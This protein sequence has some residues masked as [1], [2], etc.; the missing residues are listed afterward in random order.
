VDLFNKQVAQLADQFRS[1]SAAGRMTAGLLLLV[2]VVGAAYLFNHPLSATEGYL[3]GGEA[4]SSSQLPAIEAAFGKKNLSD[5]QVQANRICVP[6]GKQSVY[7]AALADA[8]ALPH[9]F[10]DSMKTSLDSGGPFVD[11]KKREELVKVALQE[12]LSKIIGQMNGIER[13][14]VLYNVEAPQGFNAKK[15]ITAS[16]TV[17]PVGEKTLGSE[18][19]QMIRQAVGP[20]IG[21]APESVAIVDIN[22]RAYP[23]GETE[24]TADINQ[25][26][27]LRAK[28]QYE[29]EYADSIHQALDS[30]VKGAVV[31]VNIELHPEFVDIQTAVQNNA[32]QVATDASE[33]SKSLLA[34]TLLPSGIQNATAGAPNSPLT[35]SESSNTLRNPTETT[36]QTDRNAASPPSRLVR[37]TPLTPKRVSVSVGVPSSYY[38]Q[39]WGQRNQSAASAWSAKPSP[40]AIAQLESETNANIKKIVMG[41]VPL[42]DASAGDS[43][44]VASF[45]AVSL[46]PIEKPAATDLA[47][48]WAIDHASALG[49]ALLAIVCLLIVRSMARAGATSG[50][51]QRYD[52]T[53]SRTAA[54]EEMIDIQPAQPSPVR[55]R[56]RPLAGGSPRDELV[57]IVRD[58]PDAAAE[59]LRNWIGAAN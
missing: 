32:P 55:P 31:A 44:T 10:L 41:I 35:V 25:S 54:T 38:E 51:D 50:Y 43:V 18:Q 14:T 30:F 6:Q 37:S 39:V 24:S 22:G 33:P 52:T 21:A 1:M 2:V 11:R 40:A 5:Y 53:T 27:Y 19:V 17:K 28:H 47:L 42:T 20:A 13:A 26:R 58:D 15:Q 48:G 8:G 29:K 23:G 59:V 46:A 12:E 49:I 57:E 7:M 56:R 45:A 9:N 34:K 36:A 3:F 16:V 4:V